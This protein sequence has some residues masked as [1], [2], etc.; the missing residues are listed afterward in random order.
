[1]DTKYT[2]YIIKQFVFNNKPIEYIYEH[3]L[4][5][6]NCSF[7]EYVEILKTIKNETE[8]CDYKFVSK[9]NI[10]SKYFVETLISYETLVCFRNEYNKKMILLGL[11]D[12]PQDLEKQ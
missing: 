4:N 3:I 1:M 6:L 8:Y 10:I 12:K 2:E 5:D 9:T 11:E 7:N